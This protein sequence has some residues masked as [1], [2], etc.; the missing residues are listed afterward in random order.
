MNTPTS[1]LSAEDQAVVDEEQDLLARARAALL[2]AETRAASDGGSELRSVEALRALR[3]EAASASADDLPPLLLEMNVRQKLL[4]RGGREPLPD[5]RAPY[6]AHLRVR[7]AS[8]SK[9]YLLGR[10]SFL[11]PTSGIRIVDWRVAPVAQIFYRYREGGAYEETFPGRVAEG[12]VEARR[13]VVIVGGTLVRIIGDSV[14]LTRDREGRWSR[15]G[16]EALA[17]SLGGA[18]T[19]ARPGALGV[20][21]GDGSGEGSL[22]ITAMLDAEQFAAISAPPE[23]PLLVLGSAGSGKTTVALHRLAHIAA[24]DPK[25]YPLARMSVVVPEQ[26][27][28]RLSRR[29]LQPLGVGKTQV[30]TLDAWAH[31]LARQVFGDP[32]PRVCMDAP[33]LV[34]SLKRHPALYDALRERFGGLKQEATTLKRLRRRLA[35]VIS[36]RT[37]LTN[38][39]SASAGGIPRSAIEETVRHTMLQ[40]AESGEKQMRS[41]TDPSMKRAIDNRAVWEATPEELGGTIDIEDLPIL[42]FLRAQTTGLGGPSVAHMVLD[43]AEDFALFELFVLGKLLGSPRSLTLAGDEAQQTS[44]SFAGWSRSLDTLGVGHAKTCRLAVSYR[45][46]RPV[47]ELARKILGPLAPASESRASREGAPVGR[48]DFPTEQQA[49]LFVVDAIR[50]LIEREPKASLAVLGHDADTARRC[51]ELVRELPE[52]RLVLNGDFSFDPGI[53]VTD[54]DN[55]KGLE[56]DYVVVPD[57]SAEAYPMTDDARRRLHV[58]VTRT[59]HQLW[60]VS[61]GTPSP[62]LGSSV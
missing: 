20:G 23:E 42:L 37:F 60:L 46:P 14:V 40:L 58:A 26:G 52:A 17:L 24:R 34:S 7:E 56:F 49:E 29:L 53:D 22:D 55:A 43:E 36:D 33:A 35:D 57:A 1:S 32:I 50:E 44:S 38:V 25:R 16:R 27:L 8:G 6:M 41:I 48:F 30:N 12:I 39:V 47:T 4:E 9:D 45:C 62:L 61:G 3:D 13:I 2:E 54:V 15:S 31:D 51:Y 28:A 5:R 59:S 11:D 21:V 19:A 10:S 18:G